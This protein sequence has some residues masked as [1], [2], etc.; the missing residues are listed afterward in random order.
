M[1]SDRVDIRAFFPRIFVGG[2][3]RLSSNVATRE[4]AMNGAEALAGDA[5]ELTLV[6]LR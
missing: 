6:D 1:T 3:G 5:A 4:V 2:G